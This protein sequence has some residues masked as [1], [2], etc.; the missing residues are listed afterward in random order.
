MLFG[1]NGCVWVVCGCF[2]GWFFCIGF[3]VIGVIWLGLFCGVINCV[4]SCFFVGG[5]DC[6]WIFNCVLC[7]IIGVLGVLLDGSRNLIINIMV[8]IMIFWWCI[9]G[10]GF[11]KWKLFGVC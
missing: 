1:W 9:G 3:G 7:V 11:M 2:F 4:C 8:V 10:S 6:D 5:C